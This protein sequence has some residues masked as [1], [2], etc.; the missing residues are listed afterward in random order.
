M[1]KLINKIEDITGHSDFCEIE[2]G[3][4]DSCNCYISELQE[5][6]TKELKTIKHG[7]K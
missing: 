2:E 1:K 7:N 4:E 3:L 6:F 5:L